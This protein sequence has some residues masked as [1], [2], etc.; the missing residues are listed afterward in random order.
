MGIFNF[1]NRKADLHYT[2]IVDLIGVYD[3]N[4]Y[5]EV[6]LIELIVKENINEFDPGQITQ[7]IKN[8]KKLDWQ[9][10]YEEKYLNLKGNKIIGDDFDKPENLTEF[11]IVFFFHDLD[12]KQPLITQYGLI[13]LT[14]FES[15]PTRL[16]HLISY[17]IR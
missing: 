15:L 5:N 12:L 1:F 17:E 8:N 4:N 2:N 11:R 3:I 6:K 14:G 7:K 9:T 13:K 16:S 10:A